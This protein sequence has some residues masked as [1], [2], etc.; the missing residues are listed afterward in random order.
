MRVATL[1]QI[2]LATV[3]AAGALVAGAAQARSNVDVQWSV[4]IGSGGVPV[5]NQPRPPVIVAPVRPVMVV[6]PRHAPQPIRYLPDRDRDGIPDR[7]D[8]VYNPPRAHWDRDRDGIPN[9]YDRRPGH[10]NDRDRDGVPNWRD[11]QPGR[12]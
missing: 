10:S 8:R 1:K 7:Y 2:S 9:R 5:Y 6:P 12:R 11:A 3:L 4:T